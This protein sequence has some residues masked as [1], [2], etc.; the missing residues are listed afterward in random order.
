MRKKPTGK[1]R[2]YLPIVFRLPTGDLFVK[3]GTK[4]QFYLISGEDEDLVD[5]F[6]WGISSL[7]FI[8]TTHP[9]NL[10]HKEIA[11]RLGFD[12]KLCVDHINRIK[13]DNRR[14]NL[15]AATRLLNSLN[16]SPRKT[17]VTGVP[18]VTWDKKRKMWFV[19][20]YVRKH[21]EDLDEA[22]NFVTQWRQAQVL[23]EEQKILEAHG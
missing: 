6:A 15:R 3:L 1:R 11:E 4:N 23:A 19:R 5:R 10:L 7:G 14:S 18:G 8:A 17:N 20:V 21:F 2:I 22:K 9:R 13:T 16:L 12:P